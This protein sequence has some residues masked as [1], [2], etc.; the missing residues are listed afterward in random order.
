[1]KGSSVKRMGVQWRARLSDHVV[2]LGYRWLAWG[3]AA[4][5]IALPGRPPDSL[6]RD[7]GLLVLIGVITVVAT[8]LAGSYVRLLR[9]RPLVAL[10]DL[11]ASAAIVWLSGSHV[12]PFLPYA[13]GALVLPA[14]CFGWRG[15][16]LASVVFVTL[17]LLGLGLL[18]PGAAQEPGG[19]GLIG[20]ILVPLAFA[21]AW[22]ALGQFVLAPEQPGER[23]GGRRAGPGARAPELPAGRQA[24]PL[25]PPELPGPESPSEPLTPHIGVR[26]PLLLA[27]PTAPQP[28]DQPRRLLY[29]LPV[30]PALPL[31]AAIEQ[32]ALALERQTSL[33]VRATTTGAVRPLT[34]AQ[35]AVLLRVAQEA[36]LNVQQHARA[37]SVLLT[38]CFEASAV[39]LVVQ[40]DG[41]GLLDGTY[42]RPGLHAL[43]AVRYRLAELDGQLAVFE[44]DSGGVTVRAT[45][46]LE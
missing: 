26:V 7:T 21:G 27:R 42:E 16:A 8:A 30:T 32:L 10:L 29:D 39:T 22:V 43:R 37:T 4:V 1:M 45:L 24:A 11:A 23:R 6:P 9:Q 5:L 20:R 38:L 15:A 35:Q 34:S 41:V 33:T 36:L 28:A 31:S 44:S 13:L 46:P 40:D 19:G 18:N 12:V 2:F 14:L 17:D 25:R 3:V